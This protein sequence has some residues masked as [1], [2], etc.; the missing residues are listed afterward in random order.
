MYRVD[1]KPYQ[2]GDII[3]QNT[4][5]YQESENFTDEKKRIEK[6]LSEEKPESIKVERKEGLF[7]FSGLSD[8]I[9]LCMVMTNSKIYEVQSTEDTTCYHRGDMNFT[10][11]MKSVKNQDSLKEL[12]KLYW[13]GK[14][15]FKPSWEMLVNEVE[16]T[17]IL[18][19]NENER[20][21]LKRDYHKYNG[22][23]EKIK[24]YLD[25]LS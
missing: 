15:T 12:S 8:A 14:K 5:S 16:V 24:F 13:T 19:N 3:K 1:R 22:N 11:I 4:E 23:V 2:V 20:N 10:E 25:N 6:I 9:R 7:I 17:S 21:E 18:L